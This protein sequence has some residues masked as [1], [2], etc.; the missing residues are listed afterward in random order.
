M[1]DVDYAEGVVWAV[2][3]SLDQTYDALLEMES[4]QAEFEEKESAVKVSIIEAMQG[5]DSAISS[6]EKE[7]FLE[8]LLGLGVERHQLRQ[9]HQATLDE[10][11]KDYERR[12][13]LVI[14]N[15]CR[16]LVKAVGLDLFQKALQDLTNNPS[17][18]ANHASAP[19]N[20]P[21]PPATE[22]ESEVVSPVEH[23]VR[24]P[25]AYSERPVR[26]DASSSSAVR[27]GIAATHGIY[28]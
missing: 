5:H 1:A 12:R 26:A 4:P 22:A 24:S 27:M 9:D 20:Q 19:A 18:A 6:A 28:R 13:R 23:P 14:E 21:T 8:D 17:D 2:K 25:P 10:K 7:K 11:T 3:H 16:L 15:L